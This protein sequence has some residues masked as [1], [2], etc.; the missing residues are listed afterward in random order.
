MCF[1][2]EANV[3]C[4]FFFVI[5]LFASLP[6]NQRGVSSH[7]ARPYAEPSL[8][9]FHLSEQW[10]GYHERQK[11][12]VHKFYF[13]SIIFSFIHKFAYFI[14]NS[15]CIHLLYINRSLRANQTCLL[16]G[17]RVHWTKY[18]WN[19]QHTYRLNMSE[20]LAFSCSVTSSPGGL[21][22]KIPS[23]PQFILP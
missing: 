12:I 20:Q 18:G 16:V 17:L 22:V 13:L 2:E 6:W 10:Y 5:L 3:G 19:Y 15:T 1:A 9:L 8:A 23:E 11:K 7:M 21:V 4:C 14:H